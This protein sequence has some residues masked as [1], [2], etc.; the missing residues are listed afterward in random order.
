MRVHLQLKDGTGKTFTDVA[1]ARYN[2]QR[3]MLVIRHYAAPDML[4][5]PQ[6][7]HVDVDEIQALTMDVE[8]RGGAYAGH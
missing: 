3:G 1:H 8:E 5:C 7:Y 2:P 4:A 6:I